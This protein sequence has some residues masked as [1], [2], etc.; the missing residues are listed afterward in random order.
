MTYANVRDNCNKHKKN[1]NPKENSRTTLIKSHRTNKYRQ[2]RKAHA[3]RV[4]GNC[5]WLTGGR[6]A[7]IIWYCV[8]RFH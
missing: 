2:K 1:R 4:G 3:F 7:V 8:L 6:N 5:G